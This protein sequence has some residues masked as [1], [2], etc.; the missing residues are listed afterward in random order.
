MNFNFSK[1]LGLLVVILLAYGIGR[2]LYFKPKFIN[3]EA[4]PNIIAQNIDGRTFDLTNLAGNYVL[5]DFWGSWCAPCRKENPNLVQFYKK[6]KDAQFSDAMGFEVVSVG[7]ERS[8]KSW[9]N[10]IQRDGLVWEYHVMDE[11]KDMR[12]FDAKIA[13]MFGIKEVPTKYLLN[14]KGEIIGVNLSFEEMSRLLDSRM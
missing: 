9:K 10:A 13:G 3:G 4:A 11:N 7:I 12:F 5:V 14:Q 1:S 8:E 2:Y 6:Y